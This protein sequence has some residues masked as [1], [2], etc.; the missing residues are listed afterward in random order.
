MK[1]YYREYKHS[2]AATGFS[3]VMSLVFILLMLFAALCIVESPITSLVVIPLCFA[4]AKGVVMLE[5]YIA[6]KFP[7]NQHPGIN[8]PAFDVSEEDYQRAM[9]ITSLNSWSKELKEIAQVMGKTPAQ[10]MKHFEEI[11]RNY[12]LAKYGGN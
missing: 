4:V 10:T 8:V 11:V 12:N 5:R 1:I 3:K 6:R 7:D 9:H 2:K